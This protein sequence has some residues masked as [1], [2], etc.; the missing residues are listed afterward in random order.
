MKNNLILAAVLSTVIA[1]PLPDVQSEQQQWGDATTPFLLST[2]PNDQLI[3]SNPQDGA[4]TG[5]EETNAVEPSMPFAMDLQQIAVGGGL[6]SIHSNEVVNPPTSFDV[7]ST[8]LLSSSTIPST[9]PGLTQAF[10]GSPGSDSKKGTEPAAGL[11]PGSSS[12]LPPATAPDS[13]LPPAPGSTLDQAPL[14]INSLLDT[15]GIYD[16]K[17]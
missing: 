9:D 3:A 7:A 12:S 14:D 1:S 11:A 8:D 4:Q 15:T 16:G 13:E 2:T 5:F 10:S 17:R 6:P